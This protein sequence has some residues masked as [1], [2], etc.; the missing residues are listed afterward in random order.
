MTYAL[1]FVAGVV[2]GFCALACNPPRRF[3]RIRMAGVCTVIHRFDPAA[4]C[5]YCGDAAQQQKAE[6]AGGCMGTAHVFNGNA[7]C[8]C[9]QARASW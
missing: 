5:C 4:H 1:I 6:Q 3:N 7:R 2:I 9:G 8:Q